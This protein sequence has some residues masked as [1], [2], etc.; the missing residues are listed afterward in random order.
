MSHSVAVRDLSPALK[1]ACDLLD[2]FST[3]GSLRCVVV[4]ISNT[5]EALCRSIFKP[6]LCRILIAG[7][8]DDLW[9]EHNRIEIQR[10]APVYVTELIMLT[11]TANPSQ[12][13]KANVF[14]LIQHIAG[15]WLSCRFRYH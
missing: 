11:S 7:G 13:S 9:A 5:N 14:D 6:A 10:L 2:D 8:P 15:G 4:C 1:A 12:P 3:E